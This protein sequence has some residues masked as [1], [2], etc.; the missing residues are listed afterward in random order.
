MRRTL[1]VIGTVHNPAISSGL[2]E[3][4]S[5]HSSVLR[6]PFPQSFHCSW[7]LDPDLVSIQPRLASLTFASFHLT[8]SRLASSLFLISA[9]LS[10]LLLQREQC[11]AV[12]V[13]VILHKSRA[14]RL[15]PIPSVPSRPVPPR[16]VSSSTVTFCAEPLS[17]SRTKTRTGLHCT[18]TPILCSSEIPHNGAGVIF[19]PPYLYQPP[20]ARLK[21]RDPL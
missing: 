12:L 5:L 4:S 8:S 10:R 16:L 19:V 7:S 15:H 21:S 6:T 13:H 3:P 11:E 20:A 14:N 2:W 18:T 17:R 9:S 1:Y